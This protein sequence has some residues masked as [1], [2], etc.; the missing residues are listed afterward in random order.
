MDTVLGDVETVRGACTVCGTQGWVHRRQRMLA[1]LCRACMAEHLAVH[2][3]HP[4]AA[5]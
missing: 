4:T 2:A 1:W 5:R 3:T